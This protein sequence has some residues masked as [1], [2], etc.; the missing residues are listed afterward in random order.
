MAVDVLARALD[1]WY[2]PGNADVT[3]MRKV[4]KA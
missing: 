3:A 4:T 1:T 2:R